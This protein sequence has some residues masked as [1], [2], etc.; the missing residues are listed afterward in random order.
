MRRVNC[1]NCGIKVEK[2]P[3]GDGK[4]NITSKTCQ[5]LKL[6]ISFGNVFS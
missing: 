6:N 4:N 2:V 5:N 1:P 3:W